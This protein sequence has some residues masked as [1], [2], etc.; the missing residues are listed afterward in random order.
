MRKWVWVAVVSVFTLLLLAWFAH[1]ARINSPFVQVQKELAR[2]KQLGEPTKLSDLLPPVPANQDGTLLYW[3]AI[4]QLEMAERK[5]P[6]S[7]SDSIY[8]FISRQPAKPFSLTDVQKAL[9]ETRPALQTLRKALNYP[10]MRMTDWSV[11]IP[12]NV[13][14]PQF[15]KF[16]E[17]ARLLVAEGKWRKRQGDIDG[18][19]ESHLTA[20]KLVRRI[21]DEPSLVIGFLAQGGIFAITVSGLQQVLSDADASTKSYRA[22]LAELL[23][24]DIDRDLV[25]TIQSDRVMSIITCDWMNRKASRKLLNDLD[26]LIYG[27]SYG[28]LQVNA[29]IWL[30]DKNTLI[31]HNELI[32][33]KHYEAALNLARKGVPYDRKKLKELESQWEREV[34]RPVMKLNLGGVELFWDENFAVELLIPYMSGIFDKAARF[35]A[36]QRLTQVAI[37]LRLY[38]HE[39]G[40]YPETLQELV[41]KYLPSVPVDPFDGK[42]LRYKRLKSG[43]KIWSIGQDFKDDGGVEQKPRLISG[44]IVWEAVK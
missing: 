33:L 37:A 16:R 21:G 27:S 29:A 26:R 28:P 22:L 3:Y 23:A 8:E 5:L 15:S 10:H 40:R 4:T 35:H 7:V 25:R 12:M 6:R 36:L 17:F 1:K 30:R 32:L 14:F 18:A 11:E 9:K 13:M 38:R 44:D 43:F 42:P 20:L 34:D 2:L 24:W 19:I 31:A 41:P 39:N